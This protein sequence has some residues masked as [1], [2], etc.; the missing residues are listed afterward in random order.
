MFL[1][2][3]VDSQLG[4]KHKIEQLLMFFAL[5]AASKHEESIFPCSH[6][7]LQLGLC[8]LQAVFNSKPENGVFPV[9]L[10]KVVHRSRPFIRFGANISIELISGTCCQYSRDLQHVATG[11]VKVWQPPGKGARQT[12]FPFLLIAAVTSRFPFYSTQINSIIRYLY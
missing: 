1:C 10:S 9:V 5:L 6:K 8:H 7:Y 2:S 12:T 3:V 11:V 4:F